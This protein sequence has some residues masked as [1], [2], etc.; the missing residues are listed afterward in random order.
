MFAPGVRVTV[1]VRPSPVEVMFSA[2]NSAA[3]AALPLIFSS[4]G[5]V[6]ISERVTVKLIV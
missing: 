2:G 3:L 6:S 1:R 4:S 5:A